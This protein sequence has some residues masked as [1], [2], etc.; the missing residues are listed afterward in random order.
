MPSQMLVHFAFNSILHH[1]ENASGVV[2]PSIEADYVGMSTP[3]GTVE[4]WVTNRK[5]FMT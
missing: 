2:E 4:R 1:H 5:C 3:L